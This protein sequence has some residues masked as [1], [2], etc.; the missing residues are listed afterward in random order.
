MSRFG[1]KRQQRSG[2][3]NNFLP[4]A[5]APIGEHQRSAIVSVGLLLG[6]LIVEK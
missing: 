4:T 3:T 2:S 1:T 5:S 6:R